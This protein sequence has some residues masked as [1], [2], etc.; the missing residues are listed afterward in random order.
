MHAHIVE[1]G[2]GNVV[3]VIYFCSDAC[4]QDYCDG[5]DDL[6]YE[7]WNGCHEGGDSVE[8]CA[9][10]GV[11]AGGGYECSHQRDNVVVNRFICDDGEKCECGH[12]LQLPRKLVERMG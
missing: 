1:N 4:H 5:Y 7:G 12:Y 3:D 11:V 6:P 8:F 9:S 10:C 2:A